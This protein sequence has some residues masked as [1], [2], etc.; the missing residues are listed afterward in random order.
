MYSSLCSSS[1]L[2]V[3][4]K[5]PVH[6]AAAASECDWLQV[7]MCLY[8][9]IRGQPWAVQ[10]NRHITENG[11]I[12]M[13]KCQHSRYGIHSNRTTN[14]GFQWPWQDHQCTA[15]LWNPPRPLHCY[16]DEVSQHAYE[17]FIAQQ[18]PS[19]CSLFCLGHVV[20]DVLCWCWTMPIQ[21]RPVTVWL[22]SVQPPQERTK[23]L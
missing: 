16:Q 11:N 8:W 17:G 21:P 7:I 13:V 19:P 2:W 15:L 23:G 4:F 20:L 3:L 18:C 12:V 1:R 22:T 10:Q 6:H 9:H 14:A 5:K